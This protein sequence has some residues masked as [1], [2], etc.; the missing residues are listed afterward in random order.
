[1]K[2]RKEAMKWWDK[3]PVFERLLICNEKFGEGRK[4]NALKTKEIVEL[5]EEYLIKSENK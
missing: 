3:T 5:Y 4:H 1:M 2:K